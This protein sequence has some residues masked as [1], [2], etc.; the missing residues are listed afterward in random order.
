MIS[1]EKCG[2]TSV[3]DIPLLFKEGRRDSSRAGVVTNEREAH[4]MGFRPSERKNGRTEV[5]LVLTIELDQEEDGRW[6]AEV[7][8]IPGALAYGAS[9]E[10]AEAKAQAIALNVLADRLEHGEATGDLSNIFINRPFA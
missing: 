5:V 1:E 4:R 3:L 8:D 7:V 2:L 9:S 6:I 10:Q